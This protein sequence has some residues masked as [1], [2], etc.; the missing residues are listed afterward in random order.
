MKK[1][2]KIR[3]GLKMLVKKVVAHGVEVWANEDMDE[4]RRDFCLCL[5]CKNMVQCP[6]AMALYEIC[7][8]GNLAL[9]VTRCP[10]FNKKI[11]I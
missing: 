5:N 7:K 3:K 10:N 1:L 6:D 4:R 8:T 11:E 2:W 9:A